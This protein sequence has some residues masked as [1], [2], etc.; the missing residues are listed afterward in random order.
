M[1]TLPWGDSELKFGHR[2]LS[3]IDVSKCGHQP[4][5]HPISGDTLVFNGEIYNFL[6]IRQELETLGVRFIGSSDTEVLLHALS[7]WGADCI[8]RLNG[9]FA[10]AF[11]NRERQELLLAR[12]PAGIKPLYVAESGGRL[13]FASEIRA[14]LASGLV[15][16]AIDRRGIATYFAFGALQ[17]PYTLFTAITEFPPG[18]YEVILPQ[19]RRSITRFWSFPK[20][21]HRIGVAEATS[22]LRERLTEAVRDQMFADV[23]LGVFLSSGIDSTIIAS[24]AAA[25][26]DGVYAFTVGFSDHPDLNENDIAAE[27][28][29]SLGL[30]HTAI[31][32]SDSDTLK[33]GAALAGVHGSAVGGWTEC[34]HHFRR[35]CAARD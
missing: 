26:R 30:R 17:R 7:R 22:G 31:N 2:R 8:R 6:E 28:A 21:D 16:N 19:G 29:K 25:Q 4:M 9:M 14:M 10:F 12:D 27:S 1:I 35:D 11:Y 33:R 5:V 13:I 15:S 20:P 32:V 24:L 3:I 23:P 34:L 18:C